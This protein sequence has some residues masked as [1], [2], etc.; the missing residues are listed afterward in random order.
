MQAYEDVLERYKGAAGPGA[1][2]GGRR[3]VALRVRCRWGGRAGSR[4]PGRR[5]GLSAA[6][7]PGQ[8]IYRTG[9][10][11][12]DSHVQSTALSIALVTLFSPYLAQL[13]GGETRGWLWSPPPVGSCRG[14]VGTGR[15]HPFCAL[16]GSSPESLGHLRACQGSLAPFCLSRSPI[17]R[18]AA[19]CE[20]PWFLWGRCP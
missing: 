11:L 16:C 14:G 8:C 3:G 10:E 12:S 13:E 17:G 15:S 1:G 9:I 5:A 20:P 18:V 6:L 4:P 7:S 2:V 19:E